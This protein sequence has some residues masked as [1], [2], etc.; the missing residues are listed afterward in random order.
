VD[1]VKDWKSTGNSY[2]DAIKYAA[3]AA[4]LWIFEGGHNNWYISPL[5]ALST[6][7]AGRFRDGKRGTITSADNSLNREE[8]FNEV[9]LQ[10]DYVQ[11][12]G[13]TPSTI[14]GYTT[15]PMAST[16][17]NRRV[18][19]RHYTVPW[20]VSEANA[21]AVALYRL[22]RFMLRGR[23]RSFTAAAAYWLRPGMTV[24][25]K[26]GRANYDRVLVAAVTFSPLAGSMT[27]RTYRPA[28]T[29]GYRVPTIDDDP[30]VPTWIDRLAQDVAKDVD[31]VV[32]AAPTGIVDRTVIENPVP[33]ILT[34]PTITT[35]SGSPTYTAPG[36]D[37]ACLT[38]GVL[39]YTNAA[40]AVTAMNTALGHTVEFWFR[41]ATKPIK[42]VAI[43]GMDQHWV[44]L[45]VGGFI[46]QNVGL[47]T[48]TRN[49]CDGAW[50]HIAVQVTY[51]AASALTWTNVQTWIDGTKELEKTTNTTAAASWTTRWAIGGIISASYEFGGDLDELRVST[52]VRYTGTFA[53]AATL[54]PDQRT[55]ALHHF[56][57]GPGT[58]IGGYPPRPA[59]PAGAVTFIGYN[60]PSAWL[61]L[62]RW[63]KL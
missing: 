59:A 9:K 31:A 55:L 36:K 58:D 62:D 44:G 5:P 37:G 34:P 14:L 7:Y 26:L 32:A 47:L 46:K 60:Q 40:A 24:L 35:L 12:D 3:E 41:K 17:L 28:N 53:P 54:V 50:H 11:P 49:V 48:G 43:L 4:G 19:F 27:V 18:Y 15:G 23:Q 61:T 13:V 8:W 25:V 1:V 2:Y 42:T 39:D 51:S 20:Y 21:N 16:A 33:G 56:N 52:G 29:R 63:I 45:D 30:N 10:Y 57:G 6:D 38:G 22:N